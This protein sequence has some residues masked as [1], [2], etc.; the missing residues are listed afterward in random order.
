M[1]NLIHECGKCGKRFQL[2]FYA[3]FPPSHAVDPLIH[4]NSPQRANDIVSSNSATAYRAYL[5][6]IQGAEYA[7]RAA[8]SIIYETAVR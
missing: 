1:L 5:L 4:S 8:H 3:I 7:Y 2:H 6:C